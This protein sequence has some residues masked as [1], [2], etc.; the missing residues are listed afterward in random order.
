MTDARRRPKIRCSHL[1]PESGE[2]PQEAPDSGLTPGQT[3]ASQ[4]VGGLAS[5]SGYGNGL[6][7]EAEPDGNNPV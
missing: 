5:A 7:P 3:N 1:A 4:Q 6:D 2:A